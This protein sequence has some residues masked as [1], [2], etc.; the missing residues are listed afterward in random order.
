MDRRISDLPL[1][2]DMQDGRSDVDRRSEIERRKMSRTGESSSLEEK[3]KERLKRL[4][5]GPTQ[6]LLK[7]DVIDKE[8]LKKPS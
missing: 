7:K 1:T 5:V 6:A 3:E 4:G 8:I 2:G